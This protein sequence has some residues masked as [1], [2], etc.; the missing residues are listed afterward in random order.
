MTSRGILCVSLLAMMLAGCAQRQF[1]KGH[2]LD[3]S[4]TVLVVINPKGALAVTNYGNSCRTPCYLPLLR[5]RGGDITVSLDG[6]HTERVTV[7]SS[8][9]DTAV[10]RRTADLAVEALDPDPV[11]LGLTALAQLLDGK[12]GVMALNERDLMIELRSLAPGEEDLLGNA[13]PLTGERV[14]IKLSD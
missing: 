12:G 9:S 5:A 3:P 2:G 6:F 7:T 13:E 4:E 8:V 1:V 11:G 14:P 10:A